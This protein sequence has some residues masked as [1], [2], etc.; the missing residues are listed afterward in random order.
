[1]ISRLTSAFIAL[2]GAPWQDKRAE[3]ALV[4]SEVL[5][6]SIVNDIVKKHNGRIEM[7]SKEGQYTKMKILL[8]AITEH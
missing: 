8:P 6:L 5:G 1:M 7:D 2:E 3:E 4:E